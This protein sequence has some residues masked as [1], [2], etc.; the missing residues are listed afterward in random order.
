M[1]FIGKFF[2]LTN[3]QEIEEQER[4]HGEFDL[5]VEAQEGEDAFM[6]FKQRIGELRDKGDFFQGQTRIFF[7]QLLEFDRFPRHQA[8]MLNLKSTAGDPLMPF[9]GCSIPSDQADACRIYDW[10]NNEPEIDGQN[11]KLFLEFHS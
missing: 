3:Q 7:I 4:R 6:K 8:L 1:I 10:K 9:I 11:E 2:Y 5:I